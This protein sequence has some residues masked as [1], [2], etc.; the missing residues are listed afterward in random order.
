MPAVTKTTTKTKKSPLTSAALFEPSY[1][2]PL[3][4]PGAGKKALDELAPALDELSEAELVTVRMDVEAATYAAL[5]VVGFVSSPDVRARFS[6][7]PKEEFDIA[8]L[9]ELGPACFATL[10]ALAEARAAGALETEARLPV[11][12]VTE[13][14]EVEARMQALCEYQLPDDPAIKPELDRLRPGTGHRDLANDL[15]GYARIYELRA[16]VVKADRKHY[17]PGDAA[18]ARELAGMMI[19]RLSTAM[20]PKARAAYDRYVRVWTLL[21]QRYDEVRAAGLWLWR[22]NAR[23]QERFPSLYAAGRPKVGRPRK[24]EPKAAEGGGGAGGSGGSGG[25]GEAPGLTPAPEA[26]ADSS[27]PA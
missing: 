20:T 19:Q 7:L 10:H 21:C 11:A 22:K 8:H 2:P 6:R 17:R 23:A 25:S 16:D 15:L 26:V 4:D 9:D 13:A 1:A 18:R 5:G 24:E 3:Y 12:L 27:S 14:V